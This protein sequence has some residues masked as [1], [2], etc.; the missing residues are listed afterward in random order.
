MTESLSTPRVEVDVCVYC[1]GSF[2]VPVELHHN[3]DE[4]H[5]RRQQHGALSK[6]LHENRWRVLEDADAAASALIES[7]LVTLPESV[8]SDA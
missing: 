2:P 3:E 7:G 4:C 5:S 1:H 6:W 8:T